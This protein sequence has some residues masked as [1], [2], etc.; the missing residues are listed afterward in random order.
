MASHFQ[1]CGFNPCPLLCVVGVFFSF[2]CGLAHNQTYVVRFICVSIL[3]VLYEC[4]CARVC[5]CVLSDGLA[6][7]LGCLLLPALHSG[8][9]SKLN[10]TR[11]RTSS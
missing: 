4:V 3:P 11:Y 5:V 8:I 9:A 7:C 2:L 1:G 6:S 10:V